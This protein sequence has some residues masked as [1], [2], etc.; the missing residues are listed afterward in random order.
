MEAHDI[1][2]E[3]VINI[4]PKKK[5]FKKVKWMFEEALQIAEKRRDVKGK[6]ERERYNQI[7]AENSK[8]DK[9]SS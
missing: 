5:K 7:N 2:Q 1:V 6:G 8:E 3:A 4:I 9:K